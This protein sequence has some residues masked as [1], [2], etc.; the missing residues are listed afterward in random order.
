MELLL[1]EIS[2]SEKPMGYEIGSISKRIINSVIDIN[3]EKLAD[4][5]GKGKSFV[6]AKFKYVK[7]EKRRAIQNWESQQV[8]ALDFDEGLTLEEA[9]NESYFKENAAF[10]YTT[11]SHTEENH[12]FR[13]VFVLDETVTQ[14]RHFKCIINELLERY[15]YADQACKDGSRLFFGGNKVIEFNY[16][17]RLQISNFIESTPLV[18]IESNLYMSAPRVHVKCE[19][20]DNHSVSNNVELIIS[21]DIKKLQKVIRTKPIRLSNNEVIEYLKKKDLKEFLGIKV[22][23]N[24]IDIFHNEDNPS[25]SIYVS[26]KGNG[27]WLYKCHS[28]S[29]TFTGTII[30]VV[31]RL[32]NCSILDAKKFLV[33]V[34]QIEIY[35]SEAVREVKESIDIYKELLMS[36]ELEDIHPHFYKVFN[37]Y[38]HLQDLYMLLDLSKEFVTDDSTPRIMFYHGIRTLAECFGRSRS[39]TGTRMNF[40]TLF[41][42]I[43]KLEEG[44]L[45][46]GLLAAQNKWKRAKNYQYR[47]TTY[48]IP[49]YTYDLFCEIDNMCKEWLEKGCSTKTISYEGVYRTYGREDADRVFPQ[50]KGREVAKLNEEVVSKIH[51]ATMKVIE[52]KGWTTEREVLDNIPYYFK[53]QQEFKKRQFKRCISEMIDA[54]GLEI[55]KSNKVV[56][57]MMGITEEQMDKYSFPNIIRR[58]DPVT[59]CHPLQG[60]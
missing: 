32:L 23:G 47:S 30:H 18:D 39:T 16:E 53:G 42:V 1:D 11:F 27:H 8:I 36:D 2:Y 50:D 25:A 4:E 48:E 12:K 22:L 10:V 56:K 17:N 28:E 21:Q 13:V 59:D 51:L 38:G 57:K 19:V 15:P 35:E 33:N 58:K 46:E 54:Y 41:K 49:L 45:T 55:I 44:E 29:H 34:Y 9:L 26:S 40:F 31:Q 3:V 43:R 6:P 7:G 5:L 20:F 24:F 60:E 14:Y 52:Y 37:R